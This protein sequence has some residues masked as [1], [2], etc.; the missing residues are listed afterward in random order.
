[1]KQFFTTMAG[2]FVGLCLFF[3]GLPL[4]LIGMALGSGPTTPANTV[5]EL[6][7]RKDLRDQAAANPFASLGSD[8]LS[9]IEVV[10]VLRRAET[11]PK[12]KAVLVR[13]PEGGMP[14]AAA[15]E[16]RQAFRRFRTAG[17]PIVA[18]SQGL[19]PSGA[20]I[21]TYM[22]GAA[23]GELWMQGGS[24]FQVTGIASEELFFKRAFDKYGV[25]ADF[26]QRYEYKNA[27]N[28]FLHEDYTP[29]HR[30]ATL[31]W[32]NG[33]YESALAAIARDR[34]TT[35]QAI[36]ANLEAGPW[37]AEEARARGLIDRV[38]QVQEAERA[39]LDRAGAKA[40]LV[41]FSDYAGQITT[42]ESGESIAVV[43]GEGAIVT[44]T[45]GAELFGGE[46]V[47]RSDDVAEAFY[48]AIEDDDVK[49][50]VFRVSSPGGMDTA[51]EQILAAVRA[52]K[53]A[54]KPVV[55]SM[56][57]YAAS[58]GYW[59]SSEASSIVAQPTTLTG[60][61]GVYGGKFVL[62]P[63]LSRF[64]VDVRDI[65]VG[66]AYADAY[67]TGEPF[68]EQQ[69]AAF[70]RSIDVVYE[71]F[72]QRVAR[73]RNLTPARVR[74]I[75]KGRVW[76]GAQARELGLVDELGGLYEAV[77]RAKALA[78]I[79]ADRDVPLKWF[80]G[81]KGTFEAL[82]EAFGLQAAS[83]RTTAAAAWLLA[84]PRAEA[85]M[86][87]LAAARMREQG[88]TVLADTPLR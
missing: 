17:K 63:A 31:S 26:Q 28:P 75:A 67:S 8:Q 25:S 15:D 50:I 84:D 79:P 1:M 33:V 12:V 32:M 34:K 74:E 43:G 40:E 4:I 66:G 71:E 7:L 72:V 76:T 18:H 37:T 19:A 62:G 81:E 3:I 46:D 85:M 48:D 70:S 21:S 65:G 77:A 24:S 9:V 54:G 82:E 16:L 38:G 57:T 88:A 58:G 20:V 49:A 53:A 52:A 22:L 86:D 6:D 27:V 60:S 83:V 44:G 35:P 56:G 2:V 51:S 78:K 14:P 11:D 68:T 69:R 42:P 13:L 55:V 23:T 5:L 61:I 73:G 39:I 10:R 59:I 80:P 47:M 29:A 45:G 87:R 64:G 30:E 36:R 41:E